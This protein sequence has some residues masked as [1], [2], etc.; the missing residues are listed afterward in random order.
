M[1]NRSPGYV[2]NRPSR[3]PSAVYILWSDIGQRFYIGITENVAHRHTQH[4]AGVSRWTARYA[5]SWQLVWQRA[6]ASLSEA[7][8]LESRLK[9]QRGGQGFWHITGLDPAAFCRTPGS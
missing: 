2:M 3:K 7:R 8:Q 5:G 1:S 4:N 6:C 9:A